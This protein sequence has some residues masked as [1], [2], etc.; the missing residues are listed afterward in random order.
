VEE[1]EHGTDGR[2]E[3]IHP[4]KK[5]GSKPKIRGGKRQSGTINMK[6][7]EVSGLPGMK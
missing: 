3:K 1:R 2:G 5:R 7:G 4:S 6:K